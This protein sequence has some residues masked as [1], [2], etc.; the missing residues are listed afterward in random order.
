M[1]S[2]GVRPFVLEFL[3]EKDDNG[4]PFLYYRIDGTADDFWGYAKRNG[5]ICPL[6]EEEKA[7]L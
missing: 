5:E 7:R 6:N 4:H 2:M 3:E 1:D